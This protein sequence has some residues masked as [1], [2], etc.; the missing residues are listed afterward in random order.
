MVRKVT[1]KDGSTNRAHI[2][3]KRQRSWDGMDGDEAEKNDDDEENDEEVA[4]AEDGEVPA[5]NFILS[6]L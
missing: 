5:H 6:S 2:D 4:V 3:Q 1:S